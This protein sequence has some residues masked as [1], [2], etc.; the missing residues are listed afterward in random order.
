MAV[1]CHE[2]RPGRP[3]IGCLCIGCE[4]ERERP[5]AAAT[6]GTDWSVAIAFLIG[7]GLLVLYAFDIRCGALL[8][9]VFG[10]KF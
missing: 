5:L 10:L 8:R 2:H 9:E 7:S 1:D 4:S 6:V 3:V